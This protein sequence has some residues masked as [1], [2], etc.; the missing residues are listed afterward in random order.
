VA[1]EEALTRFGA[2]EIFNTDQGAVHRLGLHERLK[3]HGLAIS[4]D[5]KRRW[6]DN[7]FIERLWRTVKYEE[8]YLK[9]Y[10][11]QRRQNQGVNNV[12]KQ[13]LRNGAALMV[14]GALIFFVY[15]VVFFFR[16]FASGGFEVGVETLNGVRRS[17]STGLIRRSWATSC[18][19]TWR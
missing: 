19:S 18:T 5:G 3:A 10:A 6:I 7:V 13:S 1:L 8:V 17:N 11:S 4:M 15:A 2:L 16:A 12:R 14:L 9:A